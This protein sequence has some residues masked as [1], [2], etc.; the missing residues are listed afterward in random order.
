[1]CKCTYH[2]LYVGSF[3]VYIVCPEILVFSRTLIGETRSLPCSS[4]A[5]GSG[6]IGEMRSTCTSG[7]V[8]GSVNMS[9]CTFRKDVPTLPILWLVELNRTNLRELEQTIAVSLLGCVYVVQ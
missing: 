9:Q 6:M 1:M 2:S 8:W 7:G 5:G 4:I 3:L